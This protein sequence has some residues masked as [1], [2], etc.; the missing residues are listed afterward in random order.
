[1]ITPN[2]KTNVKIQPGDKTNQNG[3][4]II[5]LELEVQRVPSNQ[6]K[7]TVVSLVMYPYALNMITIH[8]VQVSS[9]ILELL[10]GQLPLGG[11]GEGT[12]KHSTCENWAS[13]V[14]RLQYEH[15]T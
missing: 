1:M 8:I 3:E 2:E 7:C 10:N 9:K 15:R 5:V 6:L 12:Y 13:E 14:S 11:N 4:N